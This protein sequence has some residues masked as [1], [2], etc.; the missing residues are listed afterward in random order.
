MAEGPLFSVGNLIR[1][2]ELLYTTRVY[3]IYIGKVKEQREKGE[4]L[5]QAHDEQDEISMFAKK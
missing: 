1:R 4:K 2:Q 3:F 5:T